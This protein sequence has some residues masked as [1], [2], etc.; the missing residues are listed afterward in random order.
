MISGRRVINSLCSR[1]RESSFW[2]PAVRRRGGVA[3]LLSS[4]LENSFSV[5]KKDTDG[6]VLSVLLDIDSSSIN[7]ANI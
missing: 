5:W 6:R 3:I 4:D 7:L 2:S 1:W